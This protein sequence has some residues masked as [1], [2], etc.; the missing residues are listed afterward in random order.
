MVLGPDANWTGGD[1][2]AIGRS[3]SLD[4]A[5]PRTRDYS[6]E[7]SREIFDQ[8]IHACRVCFSVKML[9]WSITVTDDLSVVF[10]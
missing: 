8:S 4:A 7:R 9:V 2:R 3:R 5:I 6:E 1:A 10:N